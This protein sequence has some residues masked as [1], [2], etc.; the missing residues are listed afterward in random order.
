MNESLKMLIKKYETPGDFSYAR[1]TKIQ[2]K[3]YENQL[4]SR[5]PKQYTDF[6][7]QYGHGGI[8]GIV[9]LGIG[10]D[11][12]P[13]FLETTLEHRAD[14]L[15]HNFIVIENCDEWLNCID[16][17]TGQIVSWAPDFS[18]ISFSEFDEYLLSR[19]QDAI[20]NL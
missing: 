19:F 6:L 16:C 17:L 2:I 5:F 11:G 3:K 12:S 10:K 14:G 9:I 15:P 18:Q 4:K 1:I 8:G 13:I 20:E 7:L